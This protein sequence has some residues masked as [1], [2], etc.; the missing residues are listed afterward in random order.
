MKHKLAMALPWICPGTNGGEYVIC[1]DGNKGKRRTIAHVYDA[2]AAAYIV[3]AC[4]AYPA[5]VALAHKAYASVD[6]DTREEILCELRSLGEIE[7]AT[8]QC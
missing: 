6:K 7:W 8:S 5:L 4:N 2:D 3:A 1:T